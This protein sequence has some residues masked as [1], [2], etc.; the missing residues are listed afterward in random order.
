M[1]SEGRFPLCFFSSL[2]C[3]SDTFPGGKSCSATVA[4]SV[5]FS[6]AAGRY[7]E[8]IRLDFNTIKFLDLDCA[9]LGCHCSISFRYSILQ[10]SSLSI[11]E[12]E[13]SSHTVDVGKIPND[14]KWVPY[15]RHYK[16]RS[17][18]ETVFDYKLWILG[19]KIEEFRI[20]VHK[21]SVRRTTLQYKPL[22]KMR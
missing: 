20:L 11:F 18:F 7:F 4:S 16:T 6:A 17:W 1:A 13:E 3:K 14:V 12:T 2:C 10:S 21:L 19:P 8:T 5:S 15:A 22:W 9:S